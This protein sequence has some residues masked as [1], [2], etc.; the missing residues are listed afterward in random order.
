MNL[1]SFCYILK[2]ELGKQ[3][4]FLHLHT[5]ASINFNLQRNLYEWMQSS[6]RLITLAKLALNAIWLLNVYHH[7]QETIN[8]FI[9]YN[10]FWSK[11]TITLRMPCFNIYFY[12][13]VSY[14][15]HYLK[16][17]LT[18]LYIYTF[19]FVLLPFSIYSVN[20]TFVSLFI[21]FSQVEQYTLLWDKSL[22]WLIPQKGQPQ[23]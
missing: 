16:Q 3:S 15:E 18:V 19:I 9:D 8:F 4:L 2:S 11:F 12:K 10:C 14:A 21:L 22:V 17:V 7:V 5:E 20:N 6:E 13:A 1:D 23:T